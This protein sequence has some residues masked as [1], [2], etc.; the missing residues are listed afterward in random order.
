MCPARIT[1]KLR[2]GYKIKP[3]GRVAWLRVACSG[4]RNCATSTDRPRSNHV[5]P[6]IAVL[7]MIVILAILGFAV[8]KLLLWIAAIALIIWLV[9]FFMRGAGGARWYRW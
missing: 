5:R 3:T 4:A 6:L 1:P 7:L 8:V 2:T 9:G